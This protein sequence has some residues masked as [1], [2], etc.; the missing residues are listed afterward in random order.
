MKTI[1]LSRGYSATVDD[2]DFDWLSRYK[3]YASVT[4]A[5]NKTPY[6]V[7]YPLGQASGTRY[8]MHRLILAC[9]KGQQIDHLNRNGLDNRRANLRISTASQNQH[10]RGKIN[11]NTSGESGVVW[12]RR[13]RLWQAQITIN[14]K[15]IYLGCFKNI[16]DAAEAYV[17]AK[18]RN[19]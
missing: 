1:E 7:G 8:Y 19:W 12:H 5:R 15:Q 6:A 13:D 18:K 10:N 16:G 2:D 14:G 11:S 17:Q 9:S 3:W 4:T